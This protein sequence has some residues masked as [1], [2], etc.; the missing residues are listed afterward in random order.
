[1]GPAGA[2]EDADIL[3]ERRPHR[4]VGPRGSLAVPEGTAVR[5][6]SGSFVI[7]GLVDVHDH[8]ADIRRDVLDFAAWGP[9]GQSGLRSDHRVRSRRH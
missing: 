2:I 4:G 7:P 5:D 3:V 8:V 6:V 9:G 1:M